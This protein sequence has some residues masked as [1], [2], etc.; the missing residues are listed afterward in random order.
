MI[1]PISYKPRAETSGVKS[2]FVRS[3][4]MIMEN[5]TSAK[6][7]Q[8]T[9]TILSH[10]SKQYIPSLQYILYN[11]IERSDFTCIE[12]LMRYWPFEKMS[13]DLYKFCDIDMDDDWDDDRDDDAIN[14][15]RYA[16]KHHSLFCNFRHVN[17]RFGEEMI[18]AIANG[19]YA[20]VCDSRPVEQA[21]STTKQFMVDLSMVYLRDPKVP[22]KT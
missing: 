21:S 13:F 9:C 8:K 11:A 18:D 2:L 22:C 20:R 4:E 3:V 10:P 19:V 1:Q 16:R 5:A 15:Q 6:L 17:L 14:R 12:C 7:L